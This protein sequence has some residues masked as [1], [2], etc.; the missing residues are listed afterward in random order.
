MS[1]QLFVKEFKVAV[2]SKSIHKNIK[3]IEAYYVRCNLHVQHLQVT[4][5]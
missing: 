4:I 3:T 2:A 1:D 5:F